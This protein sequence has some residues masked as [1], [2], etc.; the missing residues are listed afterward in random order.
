MLHYKGRYGEGD[1]H[2]DVSTYHY[3]GGL[4]ISLWDEK[5]GPFTTL[6]VNLEGYDVKEK[7]GDNY[8]FV[9]TNNFPE[10]EEFIKKH[11]LG[12]F[13]GLGGV[14]GY[15]TYPLYKFDLERLRANA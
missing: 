8:A 7:F 6:T 2:V 4:R 1:M 10:A 13:T 9:D 12:E 11:K 3:G 14:S 5:A 15:C